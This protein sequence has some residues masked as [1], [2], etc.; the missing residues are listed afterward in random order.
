MLGV[1][2]GLRPWVGRGVSVAFS[3]LQLTLYIEEGIGP[4]C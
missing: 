2:A 4:I 3:L 1:K